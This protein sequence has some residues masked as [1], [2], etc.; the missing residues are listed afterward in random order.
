MC[1]WM[2]TPRRRVRLA[3]AY[4][5]Q[6]MEGTG[7][8]DAK[9]RGFVSTSSATGS[10]VEPELPRPWA[11]RVAGALMHRNFRLLWFAALG[12]TIGTWMQKYAQGLVV[13][14]LTQSKFYLGLD[15]F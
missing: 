11:A 13:Y 14:D 3:P 9:M 6:V 12:S 5:P 4:H 1:G 2:K 7:F 15:D 8:G 10:P